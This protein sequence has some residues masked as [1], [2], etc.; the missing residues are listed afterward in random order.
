MA[1][2]NER[3]IKNLRNGSC[4]DD[5]VRLELLKVTGFETQASA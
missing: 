4:G 3:S 5:L 2:K 1:C